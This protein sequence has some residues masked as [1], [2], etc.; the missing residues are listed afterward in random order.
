MDFR[1]H[2]AELLSAHVGMPASEV[3]ALLEV[4]PNPALGDFAFPC[5]TL[6]KALR[7]APPMIA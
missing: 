6:A 1:T 5:F 2:L 7:K 3:A 4:P